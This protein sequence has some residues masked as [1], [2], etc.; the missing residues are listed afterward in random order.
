MPSSFTKFLKKRFQNDGAYS[1]I[2]VTALKYHQEKAELLSEVIHVEV[3]ELLDKLPILIEELENSE[4]K[5]SGQQTEIFD[6]LMDLLEKE[7]N[8]NT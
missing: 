4:N 2:E 1:L 6:D 3:R 8:K 5:L 7:L